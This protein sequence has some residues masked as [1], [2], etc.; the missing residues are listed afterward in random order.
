MTR[1]YLISLLKCSALEWKF[2][3][4][5]KQS[6]TI[7]IFHHQLEAEFGTFWGIFQS[8]LSLRIHKL[9]FLICFDWILNPCLEWCFVHRFDNWWIDHVDI[10]LRSSITN[11]HCL[12]LH[13]KRSHYWNDNHWE[14][15]F[16]T[17]FLWSAHTVIGFKKTFH[18]IHASYH[19]SQI[20]WAMLF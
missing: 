4:K 17:V 11:S 5:S 13:R 14:F 7:S 15:H 10:K 6:W 12:H 2:G 3:N 1:R 16:F 8:H 19:M 9:C 18:M 20:I